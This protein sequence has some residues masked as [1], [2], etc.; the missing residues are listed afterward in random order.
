MN[1]CAFYIKYFFM[2]PVS[3]MCNL[4]FVMISLYKIQDLVHKFDSV[5][6]S[7]MILFLPAVGEDI[8]QIVLLTIIFNTIV[9][10]NMEFVY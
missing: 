7:C 2:K 3:L 8:G 1:K 9:C 4:D 5:V 10:I 6:Y